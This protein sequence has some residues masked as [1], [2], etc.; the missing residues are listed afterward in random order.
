MAWVTVKSETEMQDVQCE[1]PMSAEQA[2]SF[3]ARL[4]AA[5]DFIDPQESPD[6]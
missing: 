3:A 1:T 4:L 5:A 2:R 6:A